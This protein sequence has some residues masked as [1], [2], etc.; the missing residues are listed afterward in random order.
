VK[1]FMNV[2]EY[3]EEIH[4]VIADYLNEI[5]IEPSTEDEGRR[6]Q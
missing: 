4:A 3:S 6:K 1:R 5:E 2:D